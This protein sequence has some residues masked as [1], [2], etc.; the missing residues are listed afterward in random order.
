MAILP[1]P[2]L[3]TPRVRAA[4]RATLVLALLTVLDSPAGAQPPPDYY[5]SVDTSSREALRTTLHDV[6]DD[7]QRFPYTSTA[8]DTWDI[9]EAADQDPNLSSNILDVYR[10]ASYPKAG[11]GNTNYT[12]EHTWPKVYGF[13]DDGSD[14]YPYT[15]THAL[16]LCDDSYNYSRGYTLYR[17]CDANCLEKPT[18]LND[19]QGGGEGFYP[20]NSNWR[21]GSGR[22]GTWEIWIGRRGDVARA[23]FY[24]DVRYEGDMHGVT[25]VEEPDLILTDKASLIQKSGGVNVAKAYMGMLSVLRTWHHQDPVD[26]RERRRNDEIYGYQ[27]NPNPFIDHPE[28]VDI[29]FPPCSAP[30]TA[31]VSNETILNESREVRACQQII[32]GPNLYLDTG[33][34]LTLR[35]GGTVVFEAPFQVLEGARLAVVTGPPG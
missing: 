32:A 1:K 15:D 29:L 7:H 6:I 26:D 31:T 28:W 19:G 13:P 22:G 23:L 16:F 2:L 4:L 11:G 21:E 35:S 17:F 18:L 20:G 12:R 10:N 24:L 3:S 30:N 25:G 14:N 34:D 33:A 8:T 5:D 27:G 9:L